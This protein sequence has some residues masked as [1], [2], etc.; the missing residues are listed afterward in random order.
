MTTEDKN[1]SRRDEAQDPSR[2]GGVGSRR[3]EAPGQNKV[4]DE[5]PGEPSTKPAEGETPAE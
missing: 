3:D 5:Q 2:E 1:R 4:P